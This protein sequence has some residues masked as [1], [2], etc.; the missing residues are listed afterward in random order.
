MISFAIWQQG[1]INP[2]YLM[3]FHKKK[4]TGITHIRASS[5][6][7]TVIGWITV[8]LIMFAFPPTFSLTLFKTEIWK[9]PSTGS[10]CTC[11]NVFREIIVFLSYKDYSRDYECIPQQ[12]SPPSMK[13]E[14]DELLQHCHHPGLIC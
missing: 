6:W 9:W 3:R 5:M 12:Q 13:H 4:E 10:N 8:I 14:Y 7:I 2:K 1:W 11:N